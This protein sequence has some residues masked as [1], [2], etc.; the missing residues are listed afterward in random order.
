[1][2]VISKV[3]KQLLK[4]GLVLAV[5]GI[6]VYTFRDSAGPILEQLKKTSPA[7]VIGI[8]LMATVYQIIE[9]SIG[10]LLH[11]KKVSRMHFYVLFTGWQH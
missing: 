7:V 6:I 9:G 2:V 1:M 11:V 5:I 10:R 4:W 3:Q 8:C